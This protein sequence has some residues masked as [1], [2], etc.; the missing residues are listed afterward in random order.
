MTLAWSSNNHLTGASN[1]PPNPTIL[2]FLSAFNQRPDFDPLCGMSLHASDPNDLNITGAQAARLIQTLID[3]SRRFGIFLRSSFDAKQANSPFRLLTA[4]IVGKPSGILKA[5]L[6][7]SR[8]RGP[9]NY[10]CAGA[11]HRGALR[12][13]KPASLAEI[14]RARTPDDPPFGHRVVRR[15]CAIAPRELRQRRRSNPP[16]L[17]KICPHGSSFIAAAP[18]DLRRSAHSAHSQVEPVYFV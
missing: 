7:R 10:E 12:G 5:H 18:H 9:L 1:A 3:N 15:M 6:D 17:L 11:G 14:L 4:N 16:R 13:V 2:E 8:C